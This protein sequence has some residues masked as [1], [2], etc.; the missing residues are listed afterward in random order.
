MQKKVSAIVVLV[1]VLTGGLAYA[2]WP[3]KN[4]V[5]V[6][7]K[8]G[9]SI[10]KNIDLKPGQQ[11]VV[12]TDRGDMNIQPLI[13]THIGGMVEGYFKLPQGPQ[14]TKFLDDII[15]Q[16]EKAKKAM[17]DMEK[18]APATNPSGS[19]ATQPTKVQIRVKAGPGVEQSLPPQLR[20]Q[21]AEFAAAIA[22]RRAERGLPATQGIQ[23]MRTE[24]STVTK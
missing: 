8:P 16:Q 3:K 10:V 21:L 22:K 11:V 18:S 6:F 1:I 12:K 5:V 4:E 17:A 2:F 15:D 9:E 24:T 20:S 14:R 19:P 13:Q 7:A 23:I